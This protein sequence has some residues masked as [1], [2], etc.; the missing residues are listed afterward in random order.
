MGFNSGFKGLKSLS[1]LSLC[2]WMIFEFFRPKSWQHFSFLTS[3]FHVPLFSSHFI[4][5]PSNVNTQCKLWSPSWGPYKFLQWFSTV[6]CSISALCSRTNYFHSMFLLK[7]FMLCSS[8]SNT[9][10]FTTCRISGNQFALKASRL[11]EALANQPIETICHQPEIKR[12]FVTDVSWRTSISRNNAV[13]LSFSV[14]RFLQDIE[15]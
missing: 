10:C 14:S 11:S 9:L 15:K 6:Q 5:S 12:R 4:H 2:T 8:S 7:T 1:H 13:I 3:G